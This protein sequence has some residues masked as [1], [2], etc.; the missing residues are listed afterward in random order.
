MQKKE[1]LP[2]GTILDSGIRKYEIQDVLGQGGFGITYLAKSDILVDNIPIMAMF[3]IKEH[4]ISTMNERN[5]TSVRI[6]N[7]NNREEVKE[8][9]ES[10][11]IEANRLNKL[12]LNHPGIVRVNESF[13]ANDTAYYVMEYIKGDSLRKYVKESYPKGL[14]EKDAL[15]LFKPI[16][17]TINYLHQNN[18]THLDIK[19]DNILI[20]ENGQPVLID[21]GLSK[22]YNSLR[23]QDAVKDILP[24]NNMQES[25]H[26]PLRL[27]FMR[28]PLPYYIC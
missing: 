15:Q 24:W 22:H 1:L 13:K 8:S 16:A 4:Y 11:I 23:Q 28:W 3:A 9:I 10:F 12:S 14:S 5:G 17:E 2:I 20:R 27:I 21:F 25:R 26:S 7:E 19:P 6:S 18:V